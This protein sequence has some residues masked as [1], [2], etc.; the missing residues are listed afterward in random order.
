MQSNKP[1]VIVFTGPESTAKSTLSKQVSAAFDGMWI[2]EHAREYVEQLNRPYT[3]EDVIAIARQQIEAYEAAM[4]SGK[5]VVVFDTFLI[6]TKVWFTEVYQK[7]PDWFE[8]KLKDLKV[9]LHLLC[10]PD[11]RWVADGVRENEHKRNY[12]YEQYKFELENYGLAYQVVKG[13]G[14]ER[15]C[16]AISYVNNLLLKP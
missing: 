13:E 16:Q 14:D 11:I 1:I 4:R 9:D 15:I 2:P 7:V 6:I 5:S 12:L 8:S 10:Y 3:Y